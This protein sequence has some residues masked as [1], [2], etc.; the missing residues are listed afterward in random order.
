LPVVGDALY[1]GRPLLLSM[2]KRGYRLKPGRTERPLLARVALH[3]EELTLQHPVTGGLV[4]IRAPWPKDF[5]VAVKYLRRYAALTG[6]AP[7][8]SPAS[9][10]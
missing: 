3:A 9:N 5:T 1:N 8:S 7:T 10:R 4:T 6:D 2:L